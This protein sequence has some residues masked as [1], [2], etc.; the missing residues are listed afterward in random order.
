MPKMGEHVPFLID[1]AVDFMASS[2]AFME[3]LQKCPRSEYVPTEIPQEKARMYR[4]R[5]E[6]YRELYQPCHSEEQE[7]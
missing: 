7:K 2:Q 5:L 4:Q 1:R 6:F 3:Y